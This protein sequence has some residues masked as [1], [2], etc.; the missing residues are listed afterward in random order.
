MRGWCPID[1]GK[2]RWWQWWQ[3]Q[4]SQAAPQACLCTSSGASPAAKDSASRHQRHLRYCTPLRFIV[5]TL[6]C[7]PPRVPFAPFGGGNGGGSARSHL[8]IVSHLP[9]SLGGGEPDEKKSIPPS[10]LNSPLKVRVGGCVDSHLL[11]PITFLG[12][13]AFRSSAV[14]WQNTKPRYL[15]ISKQIYTQPP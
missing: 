4:D 6:L 10:F 15:C 5:I 2:Q 8:G 1:P 13:N 9:S 11:P 12:F 7:P 3:F 14:M